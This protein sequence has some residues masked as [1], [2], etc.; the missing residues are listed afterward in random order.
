VKINSESMD[1]GISI[2]VKTIAARMT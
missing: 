2:L 1:N